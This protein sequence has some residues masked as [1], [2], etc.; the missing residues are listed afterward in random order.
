MKIL[1]DNLY[2]MFITFVKRYLESSFLSLELKYG[3]LLVSHAS[4]DVTF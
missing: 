1:F 3:F 4:F 2:F